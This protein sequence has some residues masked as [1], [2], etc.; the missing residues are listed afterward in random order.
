MNFS[1]DAFNTDFFNNNNHADK[2]S[3][4]NKRLNKSP[5]GSMNK[6]LEKFGNDEFYTNKINS[7]D[8]NK[9]FYNHMKNTLPA[10]L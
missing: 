9:M 10:Q 3:K 5:F 7:V 2:N 1:D 6:F 8:K 4:K